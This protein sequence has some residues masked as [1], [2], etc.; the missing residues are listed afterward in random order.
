M[1]VI[2]GYVPFHPLEADPRLDMLQIHPV[3]VGTVDP[4]QVRHHLAVVMN[5]WLV[6]L[7]GF[8]MASAGCSGRF[9]HDRFAQHRPVPIELEA[10][11]VQRPPSVFTVDGVGETKHLPI[12]FQLQAQVGLKILG[13]GLSDLV[14]NFLV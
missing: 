10:H 11:E 7:I 13:D 12:S 6:P 5:S 14:Q 2:A 1:L 8:L 4:S 9:Q 3:G